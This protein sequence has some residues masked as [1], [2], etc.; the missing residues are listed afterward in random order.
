MSASTACQTCGERFEPE[1]GEPARVPL[2]LDCM[3]VFCRGCAVEHE[4]E[5][6]SAGGGR[7]GEE[8]CWNSVPLLRN[9]SH[10]AA[11]RADAFTAAY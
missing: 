2:V 6:M 5:Y 9:A 1:G 3:C 10:Y 11:G 7:C 8:V 4:A